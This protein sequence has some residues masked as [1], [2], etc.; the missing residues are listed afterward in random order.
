[1]FNQPYRYTPQSGF[2]ALQPTKLPATSPWQGSWPSSAELEEASS[3]WIQ[4]KPGQS[5][6]GSTGDWPKIGLNGQPFGP[7][8]PHLAPWYPGSQQAKAGGRPNGPLA[9]IQNERNLPEWIGHEAVAEAVAKKRHQL[10][11]GH[12]NGPVT[13]IQ[14]EMNL[15]ENLPGAVKKSFTP[16]MLQQFKRLSQPRK[17]HR[18]E[19]NPSQVPAWL[20]LSEEARNR[21]R[22]AMLP[23]LQQLAYPGGL[24]GLKETLQGW[25]PQSQEVYD[26]AMDALAQV[27][28]AGNPLGMMTPPPTPEDLA[29]PPAQASTQRT[30]WPNQMGPRPPREP[31]FGSV[32]EASDW[33]RAQREAAR[34]K[35]MADRRIPHY[36]GGPRRDELPQATRDYLSR[37]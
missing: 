15:P 24:A 6:P 25:A 34:S 33:M 22:Q 12:P 35:W 29:G 13:W 16:E 23:W 8:L 10:A 37:Y 28:S 9:W 26:R 32:S 27:K 20:N 14:N 31:R 1:M 3:T 21:I 18:F 5:F 4:G 2:R 19:F 7:R 30:S 17:Q 11:G 36:G